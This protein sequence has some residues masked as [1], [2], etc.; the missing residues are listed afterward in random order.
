MEAKDWE[1]ATRHCARAMSIPT[2][3]ISGTF[4]ETA[5]VRPTPLPLPRGSHRLSPA[6]ARKPPS[7]RADAAGRARRAARDL[8]PRVRQGESVARCGRDQPVLQALPCGRVG[9]GG[10]AGVRRVR[11]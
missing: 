9:V 11:S 4:A 3:V 5:V 8:P 2:E 1:S 6:H 10:L 7:P